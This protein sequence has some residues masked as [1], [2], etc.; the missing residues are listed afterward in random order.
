MAWTT[1]DLFAAVV[2]N[3]LPIPPP[4]AP[5]FVSYATP[6]NNQQHVIYLDQEG[7]VHELLFENSKWTHNN[8]SQKLGAKRPA[9]QFKFNAYGL[10]DR[11]YINF[12]DTSGFANT[13]RLE[14]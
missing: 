1:S 12:V 9:G 7:S 14:G 5:F 11:Q 6:G 2:S 4:A 10:D 13:F 8:L 3:G